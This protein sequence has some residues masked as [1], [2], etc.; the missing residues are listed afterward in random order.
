MACDAP[1]TTARETL[2]GCRQ[3]AECLT[4]VG[5][6]WDE[7]YNPQVETGVAHQA[8]NRRPG[9]RVVAPLAG[10]AVR[11]RQKARRRHPDAP[12]SRRVTTSGNEHFR[13]SALRRNKS[14]PLGHVEPLHRPHRHV[15]PPDR[16]WR[17]NSKLSVDPTTRKTRRRDR[18]DW[19][20]TLVGPRSWNKAPHLIP[21]FGSMIGS[22]PHVGL[23]RLILREATSAVRSTGPRRGAGH[24]NG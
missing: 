18:Q 9:A 5:D 14:I 16:F 8:C 15:R 24:P 6:A 11:A 19:L 21:G 20:P 12:L 23:K 10:K 2:R 22:P 4:L 1:V 7:S 13:G 3:V 17:W